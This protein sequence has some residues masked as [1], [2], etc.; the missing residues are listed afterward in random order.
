MNPI[1][2]L[3]WC[4]N[5]FLFMLILVIEATEYYKEDKL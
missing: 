1:W 4:A 5:L 3:I 2:F